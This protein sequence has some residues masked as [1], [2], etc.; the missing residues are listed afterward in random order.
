[1]YRTDTGWENVA[2]LNAFFAI[3]LVG[4]G[5]LLFAWRWVRVGFGPGAERLEA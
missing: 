4:N 3:A 5:L 1:L 2:L